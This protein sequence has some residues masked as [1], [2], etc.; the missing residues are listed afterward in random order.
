MRKL[1]ASMLMVS[2]LAISIPNIAAASGNANFDNIVSGSDLVINY[3]GNNRNPIKSFVKDMMSELVS[4]SIDTVTLSDME[5]LKL[6]DESFLSNNI[7]FVLA[8]S[9]N[10]LFYGMSEMDKGTFDSVIN[11]MQK[12]EK[13]ETTQSGNSLIYSSYKRE[14]FAITYYNGSFLFSD[15]VN[16]L[17][18]IISKLN[19]SKASVS[20]L[21]NEIPSDSF[22]SVLLPKNSKLLDTASNGIAESSVFSITETSDDHFQFVTNVIGNQTVYNKY[23]FSYDDFAKTPILYKSMP[24]ENSAFYIEMNDIAGILE[25]SIEMSGENSGFQIPAPYDKLLSGTSALGINFYNNSI[26]PTV[27]FLAENN[28]SSVVESLNSD[29]ITLAEGY[30]NES[31]SGSGLNTYKA[32]SSEVSNYAKKYPEIKNAG[33]TF[34]QSGDLYVISTD[35]EIQNKINGNKTLAQNNRFVTSL[36]QALNSE[37][38]SLGY[39]DLNAVSGYVEYVKNK[40][41]SS[42]NSEE[43]EVYNT[44]MDFIKNLDPWYMYA[45]GSGNKGTSNYFINL[46]VKKLSK[47]TVDSMDYSNS[48]TPFNDVDMKNAWFAKDLNNTY[49]DGIVRGSN[50]KFN[51]NAQI[52]RAE[53]ITMLVRNYN[54]EDKEA[55]LGSSVFNDVTYG[56][57]YDADM[58]IAYTYGL[59]KGDQNGNTMRPNAPIARAEAVQILKNYSGVLYGAEISE[60]PFSDV[61]QDDWYYEAVGAAYGKEIVKGASPTTFDP[62]RSLNRAEAVALINRI[63]NREFRFY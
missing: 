18:T 31:G 50:G 2:M 59:I 35:T 16:N 20:Y 45:Y 56:E 39:M 10:N 37:V 33:I 6:M 57:W 14:D 54:L 63:R 5:T 25:K 47:L 22:M 48:D 36:S 43:L 60:M 15:T 44:G 62:A 1:L 13:F 9:D 51:P 23:N 61:N 11:S 41:K 28:D 8:D 32:K 4:K 55:P 30:G 17:S 52:T 49:K 19:S 38:M 24:G 53:F 7:S 29:L 21:T 26:V 12:F 40:E 42:M 3:N 46:P 34:G 58:G 27:T